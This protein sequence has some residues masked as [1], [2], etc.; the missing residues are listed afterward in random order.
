M[1]YW[2]GYLLAIVLVAT[3]GWAGHMWLET[4][5]GEAL[6]DPGDCSESSIRPAVYLALS[7][8][9]FVGAGVAGGHGWRREL[10]RADPGH[11][12]TVASGLLLASGVVTLGLLLAVAAVEGTR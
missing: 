4:A 6:C 3:S 7:V 2:M 10:R 5:L 9:A 1:P 12:P 8:G 11:C